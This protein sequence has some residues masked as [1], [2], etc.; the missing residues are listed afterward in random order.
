[1]AKCTNFIQELFVLTSNYDGDGNGLYGESHEEVVNIL[2][3]EYPI[4]FELYKMLK[5][6]EEN[7]IT[8]QIVAFNCVNYGAFRLTESQIRL[9]KYLNKYM[10]MGVEWIPCKT[11]QPKEI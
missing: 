2:E 10:G 6:M 11:V 1:M 7:K 8:G 5:E 9:L 4:L 3:K